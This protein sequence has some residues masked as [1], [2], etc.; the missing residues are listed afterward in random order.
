MAKDI[1]LKRGNSFSLVLRW[2]HKDL[3]V[4]RSITGISKTA[5]CRV[6]VPGHG[7]TN[8]W[9]GAITNVKGMTEVNATANDVKDSDYRP[10]TVIDTDTVEFNSINAAGFKAYVSGGVLQYKAPVVLAGVLTRLRIRDKKGGAVLASSDV[11]DA[12]LNVIDAMLDPVALT[13]TYFFDADVVT[14][15]AFKKGVYDI[16]MLSPSGE[17]DEVQTG[18]VTVDED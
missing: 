8:G 3:L 5:P 15:F 16:E 11:A 14:A 12:P 13:T 6:S 10:M 9:R 18:V 17:V 1:R 4:Y 7:V 2:E